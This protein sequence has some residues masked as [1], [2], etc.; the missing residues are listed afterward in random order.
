[1]RMFMVSSCHLASHNLMGIFLL[2]L[3]SRRCSSSWTPIAT[4]P[5]GY[6]NRCSAHIKN[7]PCLTFEYCSL[8]AKNWKSPSLHS[9][10]NGTTFVLHLGNVNFAFKLISALVFWSLSCLSTCFHAEKVIYYI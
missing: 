4:H 9:T 7:S 6:K 10:S 3:V 8:G 5:S 2:V 1:M